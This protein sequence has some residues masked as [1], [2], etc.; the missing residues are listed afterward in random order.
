M[1]FALGRD[2]LH[3]FCPGQG[4]LQE[5]PPDSSTCARPT[6]PARQISH[7]IPP[8]HESAQLQKP[9]NINDQIAKF[10][11]CSRELHAKFLETSRP[12]DPEAR[13]HGHQMGELHYTEIRHAGDTPPEGFASRKTPT[14]A[15]SSTRH[16]PYPESKMECATF[17]THR[18][19]QKG[20]ASQCA[21][22]REPSLLSTRS[23]RSHV[24]T[25]PRGARDRR[26]GVRET[27]GERSRGRA[28]LHRT[29]QQEKAPGRNSD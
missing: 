15:Q 10:E 24:R 6:R 26:E 1:R 13:P 28:R 11:I 19:V 20:N 12:Q 25:R 21:A 2:H 8:R 22:Q 29:F 16:A 9:Q 7:A 14:H 23:G 18:T 27:G 5:C 3:A 17:T 4:L